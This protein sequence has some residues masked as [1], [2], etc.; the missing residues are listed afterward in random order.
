MQE[1]I[2]PFKGRNNSLS[3]NQNFLWRQDNIYIM[4]NHRAALLCWLQHINED[5]KYGLFH[6]DAHYDMARTLCNK[7]LESI[8]NLK[9]ISFENYLNIMQPEIDGDQFPAIRWDNYLTLFEQRYRNVIGSFFT[10]THKIGDPPPDTIEYEEIE[11][12]KL[13][14]VFLDFLNAYTHSGWLINV[15]LDYFFT[16]MPEE[17]DI[18]L[19]D[20]YLNQVFGAIKI[21]LDT[22]KIAALTICLSPECSGGW[23]MA[24]KMCARLCKQLGVEFALPT[25]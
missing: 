10:A 7:T 19:T 6:I 21:A 17:H 1:W 20:S 9:N 23:E 18:F 25:T 11:I 2:Y 4:D 22:G 8:P 24:E 16:R 3:F 12:H 5:S 13:P 15:D 14:E